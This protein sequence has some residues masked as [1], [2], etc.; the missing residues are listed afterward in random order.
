MSTL[1]A[2]DLQQA[3]DL[4]DRQA[5]VDHV[6]DAALA[7]LGRARG[8]V[9]EAGYGLVAAL[10]APT[11]TTTF[12]ESGERATADSSAARALTES[13]WATPS[14]SAWW[15]RAYS[16]TVTWL[17]PG[18]RPLERRGLRVAVLLQ[19]AGDPVG[20]AFGFGAV[21]HRHRDF[22]GVA[23]GAGL[24][25]AV[26]RPCGLWSSAMLVARRPWSRSATD[27]PPPEDGR[28]V[29]RR[30][31]DRPTISGARSASAAAAERAPAQPRPACAH[32]ASRRRARR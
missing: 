25:S 31:D 12:A 13:E 26:L 6:G 14:A 22:R 29:T 10:S 16:T 23:A 28:R 11:I 21:E 9:E 8:D 18:G 2:D 15:P 32:R 20:E 27:R 17:A 4:G 30:H 1:L 3:V 5:P 19:F 7:R 24:W